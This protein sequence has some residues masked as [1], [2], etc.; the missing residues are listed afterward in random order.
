MGARAR[1]SY[2]IRE[3]PSGDPKLPRVPVTAQEAS[4]ATQ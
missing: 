1:D 2:H 4:H 3:M